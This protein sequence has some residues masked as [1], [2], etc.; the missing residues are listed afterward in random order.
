[1]TNEYDNRKVQVFGKY[2][3]CCIEKDQNCK[4]PK[5]RYRLKKRPNH[6]IDHPEARWAYEEHLVI[7]NDR[8]HLKPRSSN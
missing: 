1:M 5:I 2:Y 3:I 7:W 8:V 4:P 6:S